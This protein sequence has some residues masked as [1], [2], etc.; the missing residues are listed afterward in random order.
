MHGLKTPSLESDNVMIKEIAKKIIRE[1]KNYL[2]NKD[3]RIEIMD[4]DKMEA[5]IFRRRLLYEDNIASWYLSNGFAYLTE[6]NKYFNELY[7][8]Q[9]SA[10]EKS[11]GIWA[12]DEYKNKIDLP[13]PKRTISLKPLIAVAL[14]FGF[15][16]YDNVATASDISKE[17][18][19][20]KHS[21]P[22]ADVSNLQSISG[23]K[24]IVGVVSLI[25]AAITVFLSFNEIE[26]PE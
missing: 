6:N 18:D 20:I 4:R 16:A 15:I 13:K 22:K 3:Y 23:R 26:I 24:S 2:L 10:I 17:L 9:K 12:L 25:A 8:L 14:A 21:N 5:N 1:G 11:K 19:K 7:S